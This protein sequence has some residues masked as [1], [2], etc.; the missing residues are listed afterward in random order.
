MGIHAKV[1]QLGFDA[2]IEM[3]DLDCYRRK[4]FTVLYYEKYDYNKEINKKLK[5]DN[6]KKK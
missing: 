4:K 5:Y 3:F 6:T 1:V 2:I